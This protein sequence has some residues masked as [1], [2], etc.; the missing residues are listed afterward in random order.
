M[1]AECPVCQGTGFEIRTREDGVVSAVRCA[2]D[3]Q[4][5]GQRMLR[6][7]RIPRRY[8]H[9]T[10]ESFK[11]QPADTNHGEAVRNAQDW[12]RAWPAVNHGLVLLGPPG[13]GKTHLAVA[14]ARELVL[15]KRAR[16]LFYEQRELMKILQGTFDGAATQRESEV[17]GPVHEAEVLILDDLGAGRITAWAREVMHDIIAQRYNQQ[18]PLI[19]TSNLPME[20]EAPARRPA[21]RGAESPLPLRDRLGDPLIS[22]L[23]EMCKIIELGGEDFRIRIGQVIRDY[24]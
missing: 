18:R 24:R 4:H 22:R 2:C 15:T 13:T 20:D 12:V 9:C 5:M 8:D 10:F 1:P 3:L 7:A 17:L 21:A 23:Y 19:L 16:V 11:I 14:I 6:Q